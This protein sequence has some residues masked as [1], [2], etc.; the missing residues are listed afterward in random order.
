VRGK[1]K[2]ALVRPE[3]QRLRA[4]RDARAQPAVRPEQVPAVALRAA[5]AVLRS[6]ATDAS[7][8]AAWG[9]RPG[10]RAHPA[11]TAGELWAAAPEELLAVPP[12][13]ELPAAPWEV[14]PVLGPE[15]EQRQDEQAAAQGP[16]PMVLEAEQVVLPR[17]AP[18]AEGLARVE[19]QVA[20]QAL[21]ATQR[22]GLEPERREPVQKPPAALSL[23]TV[24]PELRLPEASPA[25]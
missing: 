14:A 10:V 21:A 11:E 6:S 7:P 3:P 1:E 19:A 2:R 23:E 20:T 5:S 18:R 15:A 25:A 4:L 13:A 22:L 16:E 8:E 24:P 9:P 17:L 12:L